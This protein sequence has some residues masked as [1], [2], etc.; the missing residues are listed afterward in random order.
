MRKSL[1]FVA[2]VG[3]VLLAAGCSGVHASKS[4]SPLDF[5]IPG[6][7]GLLR[8]LLYVPSPVPP[9]P[10]APIVTIAPAMAAPTQVA[11]VR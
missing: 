2:C 9:V 1:R 5:L 3:L 6:G 8:G 11:S 7:G 10:T 4:V